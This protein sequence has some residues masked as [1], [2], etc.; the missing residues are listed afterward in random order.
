MPGVSPLGRPAGRQSQ[1]VAVVLARE[2]AQAAIAA[3][4][5]RFEP[6][7][8]RG[9]SLSGRSLLMVRFDRSTAHGQ[10]VYARHTTWSE[11]EARMFLQDLRE[12]W[13]DELS[14]FMRWQLRANPIVNA[15]VQH[16][17]VHLKAD[18]EK[19]LLITV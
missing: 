18:A 19:R 15:T 6:V 5:E 8:P 12:G 4:P 17:L 16:A 10:P 7:M 14:S 3:I 11:R 9:Y 2:L 1:S 13:L